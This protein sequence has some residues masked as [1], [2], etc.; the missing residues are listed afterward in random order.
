MAIWNVVNHETTSLNLLRTGERTFRIIQ[1][2]EPRFIL[3]GSDYTIVDAQLVSAFELLLTDQVE[4]NPIQ[5]LRRSTGEVWNNFI[6]L[7]V[8]KHI[9]P[10]KIQLAKPTGEQIWQYHHELFVS[11]ELKK[12]LEQL[13]NGELMFSEGFSY[14]A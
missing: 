10:D 14:Y 3:T 12:K 4:I 2:D 13:T 5:I 8:K 7:N 1:F 9:D 11:S 6:E